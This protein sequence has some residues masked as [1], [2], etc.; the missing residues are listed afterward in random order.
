[1]LSVNQPLHVPKSRF[2]CKKAFEVLFSLL[3]ASILV[4]ENGLQSAL[5][6]CVRNICKTYLRVIK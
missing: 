1:M 2:K 3:F 6:K 4:V 5:G